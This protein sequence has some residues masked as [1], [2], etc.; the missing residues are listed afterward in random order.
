MKMIGVMLPVL[1]LLALGIYAVAEAPS[2][3]RDEG[4]LPVGAGVTV[5]G[6]D[7]ETTVGPATSAGYGAMYGLQ[8]NFDS[9]TC[10]DKP[11][12]ANNDGKLGVGDPVFVISC[13]FR[14]GPAPVCM[15]EAD[16][17]GNCK[18]TSGDAVYFINFEMRGGPVP[19]CNDSCVW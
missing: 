8:R 17:N 14:G 18:V 15:A 5:N 10:C 19:I 11:G 4:R 2:G 16:A 13:I 1:P 7:G 3:D 6:P 9:T 12:D